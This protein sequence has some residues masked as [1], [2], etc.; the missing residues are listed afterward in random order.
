LNVEDRFILLNSGSAS[1]DVGI[2]FGGSDGVANVG[3]G[4]FWDSPSNVFGFADG[5]TS[6]ATTAT[7]DAKIGAITT[8]TAAP[9][10]A[11]T[12]QGVG[13]IH[14]KTDSEDV[15]IYTAD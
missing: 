2:I 13:S 14:V 11:P 8:S 7:H 10:A 6:T 12:F 1:G 9:T 15:Y 5:I 4:I 3:S